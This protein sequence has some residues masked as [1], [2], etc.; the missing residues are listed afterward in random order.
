MS[1][2]AVMR[3]LLLSSER[4]PDSRKHRREY[5]AQGD[6]GDAVDPREGAEDGA[7]QDGRYRLAS[8]EPSEELA[9]YRDETLAGARLGEEDSGYSEEGEGRDGAALEEGVGLAGRELD[10]GAVPDE[11]YGRDSSEHGEYRSA[12]GQRE[13]DEYAQVETVGA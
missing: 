8:A 2:L 9:E 11:E 3:P 6:D 1:P 13:D 7:G 4:P 12:E 10:E 5:G